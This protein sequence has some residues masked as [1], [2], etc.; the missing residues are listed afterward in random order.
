MLYFHHKFGSNFHLISDEH[1]VASTANWRRNAFMPLYK[2]CVVVI[3]F[4]SK[5]KSIDTVYSAKS[6]VMEISSGLLRA[7]NVVKVTEAS[8]LLYVANAPIINNNLSVNQS[9]MRA[10]PISQTSRRYGSLS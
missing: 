3:I 2:M 4:E 7:D 10:Q 5:L 1:S 6:N 8:V 9:I